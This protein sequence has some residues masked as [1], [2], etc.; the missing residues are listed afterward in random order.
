MQPDVDVADPSEHGRTLSGIRGIRLRVD[1][2][3]AK[4]KY[5]GNVDD[6]HRAVVAEHL[7]ERQG[8]GDAAALTHMRRRH[9]Y[10]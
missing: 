10:A 6:A 4:L 1:H 2:V 9:P 7:Q 3:R 8:P 5:G